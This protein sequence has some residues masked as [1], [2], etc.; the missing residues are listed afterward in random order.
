[1]ELPS[2]ILEQIAFNTRPKIEEHMLILMDKSTHEEHISQTLQTNNKQL[3][4]AVTFLSGYNGIFNV[5]KSNNKFYFTKSITDD[6]HYIMI[7]I[8][9]GAYEIESLN[10][11]IKRIIIDNEYFTSENYTFNIKMN[12]STLGSIVEISNQE[13]AI[14]FRPDDSL[15]SL[16]GFNKRTIYEE[17]NL[18]DN[19][20]DILSYDNMFLECNI[21]QGI[22]FRSKRSGIIHNF[23]MD[24]DPGYK[25]Y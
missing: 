18:S 19:P 23:T 25:I 17:Y 12:F 16:L 20:A 5:T 10:Y 22:I 7:T 2:K 14:S 15:G 4:I 1:M 13:S 21:A 9:S 11:E 24:V 3:K 6:D 8:P